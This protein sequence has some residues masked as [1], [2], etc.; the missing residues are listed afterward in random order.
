MIFGSPGG[1]GVIIRVVV[2]DPSLFYKFIICKKKKLHKCK[3]L[4]DLFKKKKNKVAGYP[5]FF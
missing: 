1:F 5:L 4:L 2:D 3:K